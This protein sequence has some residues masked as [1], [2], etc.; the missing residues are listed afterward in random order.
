MTFAADRLLVAGGAGFIGSHFARHW[1]ASRRQTHLVVLDVL[2]YAAGVDNLAGLESDPRFT[3][4]SGDIRDH[5]LVSRLLSEHD[6]DAVVNFAAESHVDRSILAPGV[7]LE[8]NVLGAHVLLESAASYWLRSG[9]PP[10]AHRFLQVSTDEVYGSLS[11]GDEPCTEEAPYLPNSPYSASK[12]AADHMVRAYHRT[13]GLATLVVHAPNNFG[14]RQFPEKLIPRVITSA[15]EGRTIPLYGD[16]QHVREWL[17]VGDCCVGIEHVLT[18]GVPGERYN[19]PRAI[20]LENRWLVAMICEL[21]DARL[22]AR[23]EWL[24]AFPKS[25]VSF[26]GSSQALIQSV[27]DRPGH[28]RRYALD[29][30]KARRELGLAAPR[31]FEPALAETVDWYLANPS[32]WRGRVG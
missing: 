8:T 29:A 15:L 6:I 3:L 28:D 19:L 9:Q 4:V 20:S 7:F 1:L 18:R 30:S 14:P 5:A 32:W 11:A 27:A 13:Y 26:G 16:G 12:A 23:P 24:Q 10:R 2:T 17:Y 25:K 21:I 22:R 31:E